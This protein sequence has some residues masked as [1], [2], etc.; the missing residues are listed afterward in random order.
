MAINEVTFNS[1]NF[2]QDLGAA[3]SAPISYP[4]PTEVKELVKIKGANGSLTEATGYYNNIEIDAKFKVLIGRG[5]EEGCDTFEG[6]KRK[7]SKIFNGINDNRLMFSDIENRCY[8]VKSA[9]VGPV[10]K[11][12]DYEAT[13]EV[14]FNCDPFLY[15]P[16]E[17]YIETHSDHTRLTYNYDG[18]VR[19]IV[20]IELTMAGKGAISIG[21]NGSVFRFEATGQP[22]Y[23]INRNPF[24]LVNDGNGVGVPSSGVQP[25]SKIG[26]NEITISSIGGNIKEILKK[27]RIYKNTRYLG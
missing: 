20:V 6:V 22:T 9:G 27:V 25:V 1:V 18:D 15:N 10:T 19:N 26:Q 4:V 16:D 2:W 23:Y 17:G 7:I 13:F 12:S 3:L 24:T 8:R 5:Q 14:T 11:I 21:C